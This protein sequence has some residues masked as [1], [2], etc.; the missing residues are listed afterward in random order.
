[1]YVF[2]RILFTKKTHFDKYVCRWLTL[3]RTLKEHNDCLSNTSHVQ[4]FCE[5]ISDPCFDNAIDQ[6]LYE[7]SVYLHTFEKM[8]K[9]LTSSIA[10]KA[11]P[12]TSRTS[13][14][15]SSTCNNSFKGK[16]NTLSDT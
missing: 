1:M 7:D 15:M 3:R 12:E 9:Y 2:G 13:Q 6:V 4:E 16:N 14:N 10:T 8:H 5:G 11:S